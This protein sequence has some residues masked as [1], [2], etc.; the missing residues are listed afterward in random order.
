[1]NISLEPRKRLTILVIML[2]LHMGLLQSSQPTGS[3]S[4]LK[5]ETNWVG[6]AYIVQDA[7]GRNIRKLPLALRI[8]K[9]GK[10]GFYGTIWPVTNLLLKVEAKVNEA[11]KVT[12]KVV[13]VL[14]RK[15]EPPSI[16][17]KDIVFEGQVKDKIIEG[18]ITWPLQEKGFRMRGRFELKLVE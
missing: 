17:V 4:A 9:T 11:D 18:T 10:D 8:E 15:D 5:A 13:D 12:M 1:M 6:Q 2:P 16:W 3:A 14:R 7:T